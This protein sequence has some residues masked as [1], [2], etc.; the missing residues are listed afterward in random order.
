MGLRIAWLPTSIVAVALCLAACSTSSEYKVK[1]HATPG[2][3]YSS[4]HTF[5]LMPLPNIS[6][7][8]DPGLMARVSEPARQA[9]I[10]ALVAK[11]LSQVDHQHADIAVNLKSQFL[12]KVKVSDWGYMPLPTSRTP[13]G[14][15]EGGNRYRGADE[16]DYEERT[17]TIEIFDNRTKALAWQGSAKRDSTAEVDVEKV[18][19]AIAQ[20]LAE[21]PAGTSASKP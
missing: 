13:L 19:A 8:T 7:V 12:P 6:P 21:F 10:D 17:L 14:S 9:T 2:T 16:T 18:K 11:G 15:Q 5:A 20:I 4:Y 1:T 3:D